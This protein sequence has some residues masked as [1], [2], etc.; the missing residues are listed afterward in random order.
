MLLATILY[1]QGVHKFQLLSKHGLI[2]G[3]LHGCTTKTWKNLQ[4]CE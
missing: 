1:T 2:V 3:Y 4:Y